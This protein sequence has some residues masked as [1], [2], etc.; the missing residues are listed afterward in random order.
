M[1]MER[2]YSITTRQ[3]RSM[4][5][6]VYDEIWDE[7]NRVLGV[8]LIHAF[9]LSSDMYREPTLLFG[10]L[11]SSLLDRWGGVKLVLPDLPGFGESAAFA[12][13]PDSLQWY[14]DS[15]N[16]I[17]KKEN[18]EDIVIGGCSMGGYIA[19]AYVGR[20]DSL[21]LVLIDTRT[22]ADTQEGRD[23]RI[24]TAK[25]IATATRTFPDAGNIGRLTLR[26]ASIR[27][28]VEGLSSKLISERSKD[29]TLLRSILD[30]QNPEAIRQALYGMAGRKDTSDVLRNYQGKV[31]IVVGE[32]DVLTPVN[33][34][35]EMA[36]LAKKSELRVV[37]GSGHLVPF[38]KAEEFRAILSEWLS[39]V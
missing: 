29:K 26:S 11:R 3:G 19:L 34:S 31:L 20:Y 10:S 23:G 8:V 21:G 5:V 28:F 7:S 25:M 24:S 38:E 12:K 18:L 37:K 1:D 32:E 27:E 9:P 16:D 14:V 2:S 4:F 36:N 15:I 6:N 33:Y 39:T 35:K 13:P 22:A 30:S 17:V